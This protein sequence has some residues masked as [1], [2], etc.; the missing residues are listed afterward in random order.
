MILRLICQSKA[1][2]L[3]LRPPETHIKTTH[4]ITI[5]MSFPLGL[6]FNTSPNSLIWSPQIYVLGCVLL[7]F[8]FPSMH[9]EVFHPATTGLSIHFICFL[10]DWDNVDKNDRI[11][12]SFLFFFFFL[13]KSNCLFRRGSLCGSINKI[14]CSALILNRENLSLQSLGFT[15]VKHTKWILSSIGLETRSFPFLGDFCRFNWSL[16]WSMTGG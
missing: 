8:Y 4:L 14:T 1:T 15:N 16:V 6:I 7:S 5:G 13:P 9:V 11:V 3:F 12:F 10:S 2:L